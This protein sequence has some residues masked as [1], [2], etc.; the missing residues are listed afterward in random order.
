MQE[1]Q[2]QNKRLFSSADVKPLIEGI[3]KIFE[4]YSNN[5]KQNYSELSKILKNQ[6][7]PHHLKDKMVGIYEAESKEKRRNVR[8]VGDITRTLGSGALGYKISKELTKNLFT[9]DKYA[10]EKR[11]VIQLGCTILTGHIG[12]KLTKSK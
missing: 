4:I 8:I 1:L 9:D 11:A 7:V 12:Y 5:K 3:K 10:N 6:N 2:N